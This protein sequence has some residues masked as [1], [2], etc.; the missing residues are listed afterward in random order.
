MYSE[1]LSYTATISEVLFLCEQIPMKSQI[2][3]LNVF[4]NFRGL[5]SKKDT[6]SSSFS[7]VITFHH[8]LVSISI[9]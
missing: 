9:T 3:Q 2:L 5:L 1:Q 8:I 4:K 6:V 7:S